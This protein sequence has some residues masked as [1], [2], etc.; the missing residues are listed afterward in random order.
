MRA[1]REKSST[2]APTVEIEN[3][4]NARVRPA[5]PGEEGE[6]QRR[7]Y[8]F[9]VDE[10]SRVVSM[11]SGGGVARDRGLRDGGV[12]DDAD[13]VGNRKC[14]AAHRVVTEPYRGCGTPLWV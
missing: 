10:M 5:R 8:E 12:G 13:G 3:D 2:S 4:R 9:I 1:R 7:E 6:L 11:S 14:R